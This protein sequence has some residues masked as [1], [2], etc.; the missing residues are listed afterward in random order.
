MMYEEICKFRPGVAAPKEPLFTPPKT[1]T[2]PLC[3][4]RIEETSPL[5]NVAARNV[6]GDKDVGARGAGI[7][8]SRWEAVPSFA[9]DLQL[10]CSTDR[11]S[12]DTNDTVPGIHLFGRSD[13]NTLYASGDSTDLTRSHS[14][15]L[16]SSLSAS[17]DF[18]PIASSQGPSQSSASG[19]SVAEKGIAH[20]MVRRKSETLPTPAPHAKEAHSLPPAVPRLPHQS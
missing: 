11:Q 18:G 8:Y 9:T 6:F 12:C 14:T 10:R 7:C 4:P 15:H 13:S 20:Q 1:T 3:S 5:D 19:D 2:S 16:A 17:Y